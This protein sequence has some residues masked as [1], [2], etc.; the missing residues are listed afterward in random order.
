M[1]SSG[2]SVAGM[3]FSVR[4]AAGRAVAGFAVMRTSFQSGEGPET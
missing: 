3:A 2:A 1:T 4:V